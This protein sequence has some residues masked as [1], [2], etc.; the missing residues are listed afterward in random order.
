M[1][2]VKLTPISESKK[3][4]QLFGSKHSHKFYCGTCGIGGK[5]GLP[6]PTPCR[7]NC[8]FSFLHVNN[9]FPMFYLV[10]G[11]KI[12]LN[13]ESVTVSSHRYHKCKLMALRAASIKMGC[14]FWCTNN[15][16]INFRSFDG[17]ED[18]QKIVSHQGT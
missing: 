2:C 7:F 18:T 8:K 15:V 10:F 1:Y 13:S 9:F 11:I 5:V 3:K 6:N 4:R 17:T 12:L 14:C 16:L